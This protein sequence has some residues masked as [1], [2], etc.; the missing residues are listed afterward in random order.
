MATDIRRHIRLVV[1]AAMLLLDA[2]LFAIWSLGGINWYWAFGVL[3]L[4]YAGVVM[5]ATWSLM[6]QPPLS[7]PRLWMSI[8]FSSF[9][10]SALAL[11]FFLKN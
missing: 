8:W 11:F 9:V 6:R 3:L 1:L 2:A 5:S 4:P 10:G 7:T